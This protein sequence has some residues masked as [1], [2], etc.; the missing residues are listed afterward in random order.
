MPVTLPRSTWAWQ[1]LGTLV[2]LFSFVCLA[3]G[4]PVQTKTK[5]SHKRSADSGKRSFE[6]PAAHFQ[7]EPDPPNPSTLNWAPNIENSFSQGELKLVDNEL[8]IQQTGLYFIYTQATFGGLQC[9]KNLNIV[10]LTVILYSDEHEEKMQLL[11]ADKTPC[12]QP[13]VTTV[14]KGNRAGWNKSIFLGGAFRLVKGDKLYVV[15]T[16]TEYVKRENGATYFGVYA[17]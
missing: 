16:G 2:V 12:E 6:R 7:V 17:L 13:E 15:T 1:S 10:S 5:T 3:A 8:H 11:R 14:N 9:P 4:S